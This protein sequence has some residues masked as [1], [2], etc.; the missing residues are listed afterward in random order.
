MGGLGSKLTSQAVS[1][2]TD[3]VAKVKTKPRSSSG[4]TK[5]SNNRPAARIDDSPSP[6]I[7]LAAARLMD[8]EP[9]KERWHQIARESQGRE[10][11]ITTWVVGEG[12]GRRG[13]AIRSV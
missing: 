8:L 2:A 3:Q 10:N 11:C 12:D 13:T 5:L 4:S 7:G 9:E 6:S 1:E